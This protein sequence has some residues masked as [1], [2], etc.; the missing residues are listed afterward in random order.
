MDPEIPKDLCQSSITNILGDNLYTHIISILYYI[1]ILYNIHTH[2]M[3]FYPSPLQ[4]L[5][6][7]GPCQDLASKHGRHL[8]PAAGGK[9]AVEIPSSSGDPVM[10][11]LVPVDSVKVSTSCDLPK[12]KGASNIKPLVIPSRAMTLS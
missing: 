12:P 9:V 10:K 2:N 5:F 3:S 8:A 1:P 11:E 4:V 7:H 6:H